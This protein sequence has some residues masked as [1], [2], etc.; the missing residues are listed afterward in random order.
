LQSGES[1]LQ[2]LFAAQMS[3]RESFFETENIL[4]LN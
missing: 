2:P 4:G 3:A 1:L